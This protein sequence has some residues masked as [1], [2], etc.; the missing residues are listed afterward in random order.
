MSINQTPLPTIDQ[1]IASFPSGVGIVLERIRRTIKHAA[2]AAEEKI[3]YKIPAFF[4]NGN[5]VHFA[6]FKKHIGLYP[7]PRNGT[8]K[9]QKALSAYLGAKHSVRFPLDEPIPFELIGQLVKV[10][11]KENSE[12]AE[13][14]RK[15]SQRGAKRPGSR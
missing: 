13:A 2:P 11:L 1:Y 5:L 12:R 10:R 3:S 6:A 15:R 14:K 9:F 4:L 8:K 7:A